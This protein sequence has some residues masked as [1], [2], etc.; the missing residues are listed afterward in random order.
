M[1]KIMIGKI[2]AGIAPAVIIGTMVN[3]KPNFLTINHYGSIFPAQYLICIS[4]M[5]ERYTNIGI[6][7]NRGFSINWPS[8][9]LVHKTDYVGQYSGKIVDKSNIFEIFYGSDGKTP[10]IKECPI[11]MACKIIQTFDIPTRDVYIGEV[12]ETFVAK[13]CCEGDKPLIDKINPLMVGGGFYWELGSKVG[14]MYSDGKT[15]M[16]RITP[17]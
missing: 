2:V 16:K 15:L 8:K 3:G 6:K 10:M 17:R 1:E 14:N 5:R 11:N 7:E 4:V 13:D 12:M 9:D